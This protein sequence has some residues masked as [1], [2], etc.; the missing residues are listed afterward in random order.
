MAYSSGG[1]C[2][3]DHP[4]ALP[5]LTIAV[6]WNATPA[7]ASVSLSSGPAYTMH[8]DFLNSWRQGALESLVSRCL[9]A[10]LNCGEITAAERAGGAAA[11][12]PP[13]PRTPTPAAAPGTVRP[14]ALTPAAAA[15][16]GTTTS[17]APATGSG[18]P[19][20]PLATRPSAPI[21]SC[22]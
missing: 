15:A 16:A 12:P 5:R 8:A 14:A 20:A 2:P 19:T 7:P 3:A 10:H 1:R 21:R 18:C 17:A 6:G 4:V 11:T 22:S 13:A 9:A